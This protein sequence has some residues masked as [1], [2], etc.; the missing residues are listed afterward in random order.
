MVAIA[1]AGTAIHSRA[2]VDAAVQPM[3]RAGMLAAATTMALTT[4]DLL[5]DP[6][7]IRAAKEEFA[8]G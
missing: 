2:F 3:A 6:G 4:Y 8:R 7:R 5:A 1:P